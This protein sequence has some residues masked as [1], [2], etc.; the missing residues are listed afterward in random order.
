MVIDGQTRLPEGRALA[1]LDHVGP[2][3][4]EAYCIGWVPAAFS[5]T[6]F[7]KHKTGV[8]GD[9]WLARPVK[10]ATQQPVASRKESIP[11]RSG[12]EANAVPHGWIWV[13]RIQAAW[14]A[15]NRKFRGDSVLLLSV[16][17]SFFLLEAHDDLGWE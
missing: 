11:C 8:T 5:P 3:P 2:L 6:V 4:G 12:S 9:R 15:R 10:I 1:R 13:C 7:G 17:I 14:Q 16:F